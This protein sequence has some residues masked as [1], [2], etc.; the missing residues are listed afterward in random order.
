MAF[1]LKSDERT[2]R[3]TQVY[4]DGEYHIRAVHPLH[5]HS[6]EALQV[7]LD[8]CDCQSEPPAT[9]EAFERL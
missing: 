8:S 7:S 6:G 9:Q 2:E 5:E 4:C 1:E 3:R